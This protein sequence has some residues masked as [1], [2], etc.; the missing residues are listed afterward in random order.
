M[1][2]RI[3]RSS[4]PEISISL[5]GGKLSVT[6]PVGSKVTIHDLSGKQVMQVI[7]SEVTEQIEL[8]GHGIWLV[9]CGNRTKKV[10]L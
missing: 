9:K 4:A 5:D 6:A 2:T 10:S 7:T 8:P 1:P 3:A